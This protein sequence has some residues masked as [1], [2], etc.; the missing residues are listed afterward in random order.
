MTR[1]VVVTAA[2]RADEGPGASADPSPV[3]LAR[4]RRVDHYAR[5]ALLAGA[6]ALARAGVSRPASPDADAGVVVGSAWGCRGSILSHA[7]SL[8][9][10]AEGADPPSPAVFAQ[11]VHNSACGEL[12][13]AWN[14]GGVSEAILSGPTAGLEAILSAS[15]RV[16]AGSAALVVAVGV[17]G[18]D[19]A[20][21]PAWEAARRRFGARAPT[22]AGGGAALVLER[23]GRPGAAPLAA[24]ADGTLLFEPDP[25]RA[26]ERLAAWL[27]AAGHP[28][29]TLPLVL[30]SPDLD[31]CLDPGPLR[32]AGL[33][34]EILGPEP[35]DGDAFGAAGAL[36]AVRAVERIGRGGGACAVLVRDPEGPAAA[37]VLTAAGG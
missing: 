10:G 15:D 30:P 7:R 34:G 27:R 37:L 13:V 6:R 28:L 35:P 18:A 5:T 31:G 32:R 9:R 21:L 33:A 24:V 12:A 17:D 20:L 2:A 26:R 25:V 29:G 23:P 1:R 3:D 36:G 22:F 11:T 4:L 19:P 16:R 14:L 8:L